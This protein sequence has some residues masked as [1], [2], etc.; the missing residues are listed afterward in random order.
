MHNSPLPF[1]VVVHM[2][3]GYRIAARKFQILLNNSKSS[4]D[5]RRFCV[6][7]YIHKILLQSR[8]LKRKSKA[9]QYQEKPSGHPPCV[10]LFSTNE[11]DPRLCRSE[12]CIGGDLKITFSLKRKRSCRKRL[13]WRTRNSG[14]GFHPSICRLCCRPPHRQCLRLS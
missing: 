4:I 5:S 6:L 2:E 9:V 11:K 10:S 8:L 3:M 7:F 1:L 14:D 12:A 13:G